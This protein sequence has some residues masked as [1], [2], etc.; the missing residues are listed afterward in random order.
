MIID[1][2]KVSHENFTHNKKF[3]RYIYAGH[4]Q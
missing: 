3:I 2:K 4:E 1:D